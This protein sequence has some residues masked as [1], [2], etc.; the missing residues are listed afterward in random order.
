MG[1]LVAEA[2]LL[3]K[4]ARGF[5]PSQDWLHNFDSLPYAEDEL[6]DPDY[7]DGPN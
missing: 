1:V 6:P 3:H 2:E 5:R 4:D 7:S